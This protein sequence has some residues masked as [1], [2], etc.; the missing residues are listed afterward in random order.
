MKEKVMRANSYLT[1][2]MYVRRSIQMRTGRFGAKNENIAH[3]TNTLAECECGCTA[4]W[5][6]NSVF[7]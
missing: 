7:L 6:Q 1:V 4:F 2:S 3:T 5:R